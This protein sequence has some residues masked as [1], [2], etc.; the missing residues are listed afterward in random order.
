[1]VGTGRLGFL[2]L[3]LGGTGTGQAAE[4]GVEN[5]GDEPERD[6]DEKQ[7]ESTG[8]PQSHGD[9][10]H[11]AP[12]HDGWPAERFAGATKPIAP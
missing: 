7:M 4:E 9:G 1:M 6:G 12:R 11:D 8:K 2:W 5:G 3:D 10:Y